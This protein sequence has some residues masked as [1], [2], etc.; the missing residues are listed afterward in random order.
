MWRW[1][2]TCRVTVTVPVLAR[3]S[4]PGRVHIDLIYN[5]TRRLHLSG[6]HYVNNRVCQ[7]Q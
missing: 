2:V 6:Y 5:V 3:E 1:H 4:F 7:R